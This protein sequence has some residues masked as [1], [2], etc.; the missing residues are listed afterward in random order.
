[1]EVFMA[2]ELI[3][4]VP[5]HA[6]AL[7]KIFWDAF[8]G[9]STAHGFPMDV[10][11]LEVANMFMGSITSRPDYYGV[12][13]VEGGKIIGCNF[14]LLAD[15]VS[16]VGPICI[17]PKSQS[18]GTGRLLMK[19]IV[20]YS[21]EK[22]GPMVRLLQDSFNMTSLSLYTSLGF[23]VQEPMVLMET[24]PAGSADGAVRALV[25]EDVAECDALC[26]K[27]YRVSRKNELGVMIEFGPMAEA[28]PVGKFVGGKLAAFL[29]PGFVGFGV[30]ESDGD[31]L[32]CAQQA[33]RVSP[34]H[35]RRMFVPA[36][37]GEMMREAL[38]RGFR[39]LKVMNLMSI[40][41]YEGPVGSWSSSV[42]Y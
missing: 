33:A 8:E 35:N 22:H 18:R 11:N 13:A 42:I 29:I 24:V 28:V 26:Q 32:D 14:T 16:G 7:G 37:R 17:D 39:S 4:A 27:I 10:P 1:L 2:V 25:A 38:R 23:T 19:H 30:G 41:R 12:V 36:R 6:L 3:R 9:I 40:G 15:G 34:E 21:L 5:E 31:L 20:D